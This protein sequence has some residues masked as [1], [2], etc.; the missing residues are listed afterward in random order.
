MLED[1]IIFMNNRLERDQ[2]PQNPSPYE[3]IE[4]LYEDAK[5]HLVVHQ[6]G[7]PVKI[8]LG[9][10]SMREITHQPD[11]NIYIIADKDTDVSY[12]L[13][14]EGLVLMH[15]EKGEID[16]PE[17]QQQTSASIIVNEIIESV[18]QTT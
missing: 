3:L 10:R 13:S 16:I 5:S 18:Y 9:K 8:A 4:E 11:N 2:S 1:R 17:D 15:T 6:P 7:E 14:P 12:V